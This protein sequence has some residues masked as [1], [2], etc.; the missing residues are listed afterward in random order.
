[1]QQNRQKDKR[2]RPK[3]NR[4][5]KKEGEPEH[6][7]PRVEIASAGSNQSTDTNERQIKLKHRAAGSALTCRF[8]VII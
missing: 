4:A 8:V 2:G 6:M 5:G 1:M 7:K 3:R